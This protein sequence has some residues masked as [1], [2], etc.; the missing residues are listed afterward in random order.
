MSDGDA[1][2]ALR[3]PYRRA[4]AS[5]SRRDCPSS[6]TL[7][8]LAAGELAGTEREQISDHLGFCADCAEEYQIARS[9]KPWAEA[10]AVHNAK[11]RLLVP[12]WAW[13][14]AAAVVISASSAFWAY[15]E[16][17]RARAT[18][19]QANQLAAQSR[20]DMFALRRRFD[21]LSR[22]QLDMVVADLFPPDTTR[23]DRSANA[24]SEQV[25][26]VP[27]DAR[28]FTAILNLPQPTP[29]DEFGLEI[30]SDTGAAVWQGGGLHKSR[31]N[32]VTIALPTTITPAGVYRFTV[33]T[34]SEG[35]R[36]VQEYNVR[37]Q[38]Q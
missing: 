20:E 6:E 34:A 22:P 11:R 28:W 27:R 23:G 35:Q 1:D 32:T 24:R 29:G 30:R 25:I 4:T 13:A 26:L 19:E 36:P 8:R 9:L 17:D 10:A 33:R 37:I 2:A 5:R 21:E 15:R 14:T 18:T 12:A 16:G 7:A 38:Q 3:E 31:Y